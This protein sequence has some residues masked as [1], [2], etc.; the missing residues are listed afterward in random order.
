M[1]RKNKKPDSDDI[2]DLQRIGNIADATML[3]ACLKIN[4]NENQYILNLKLEKSHVLDILRSLLRKSLHPSHCPPGI[5]NNPAPSETEIW[6]DENTYLT[7]REFEI[8]KFVSDGLYNKEVADKLGLKNST[9]RNT[10]YR[11]YIKLKTANRTE[12]SNKFKEI[13]NNQKNIQI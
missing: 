3:D 2:S 6:V 4:T 7:A 8:M 12:A 9:V 1:K 10:L 13:Y 5:K 11:A